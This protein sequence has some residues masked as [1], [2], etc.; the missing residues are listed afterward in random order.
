[1]KVRLISKSIPVTP[2]YPGM[3]MSAEA[4]M[5]YIARVSSPNQEN[6]DYTKLLAYCM[7]N[8]HWS[9]FEH[10]Y[11][12]VEVESS[13]AIIRQLLRHRSFVF[14]EFSQRY[15]QVSDERVRVVAR[16]QDVKNRQNSTDTLD[17]DTKEDFEHSQN[18]VWDLCI[19]EY[20]TALKN[21]VA[22]ECARALLPEGLAPSR[23][24][25]TGSVRTWLHYLEVRMGNGT[26][27]EHS[28]IAKAIYELLAPEL[29]SCFSG[30][31][32]PQS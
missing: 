30:L 19:R 1:M 26:Q 27:K 17:D 20:N 11:F 7:R 9:V 24:Y 32:L 16:A 23:L 28:D 3:E 25:M 29:P 5:A 18:L 22:K 10:S 12:T 14:S 21:G 8:K 6:P 13:R 4:L 2:L 31:S 15:S